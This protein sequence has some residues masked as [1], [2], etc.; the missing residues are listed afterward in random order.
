MISLAFLIKMMIIRIVRI[1]G[2]Q[3][4]VSFGADQCGVIFFVLTKSQSCE[5]EENVVTKEN[6][7]LLKFFIIHSTR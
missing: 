1:P 5:L 2:L 3:I 7:I 4:I 6:A